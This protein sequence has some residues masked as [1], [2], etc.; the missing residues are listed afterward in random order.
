M[1]LPVFSGHSVVAR[2]VAPCAGWLLALLLAGLGATAQAADPQIDQ[3]RMLFQQT[4]PACATC[5][6]LREAGATGAIGPD[7]DELQPDQD[8]IRAVLRDGSGAMPSFADRLS[9][10]QIKAVTA[11]VLWATRPR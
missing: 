8:Q 4:S 11:Y 5:H 10:Q 9:E 3:G 1:Q 7:L 6:A 2:A